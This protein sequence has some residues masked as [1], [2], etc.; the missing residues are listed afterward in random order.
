MSRVYI[1][2]FDMPETCSKCPFIKY[3]DCDN[4]T[5]CKASRKFL[6]NASPDKMRHPD[7]QL[8]FK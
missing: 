1:E 6:W 2:D 5:S 3:W 4:E 7:C 8:K